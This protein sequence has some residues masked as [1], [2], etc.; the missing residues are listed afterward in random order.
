[1]NETLK[2]I[3]YIF[4]YSSQDEFEIIDILEDGYIIQNLSDSEETI[5]IDFDEVL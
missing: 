5:K 4:N 2:E 1:M 3:E